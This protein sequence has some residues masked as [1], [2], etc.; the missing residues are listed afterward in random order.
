[1]FVN[2]KSPTWL[3]F[4]PWHSKSAS[5]LLFLLFIFGLFV[6]RTPSSRRSWCN[7][8]ECCIVGNGVRVGGASMPSPGLLQLWRWLLRPSVSVRETRK[9]R[10]RY[11]PATQNENV[12][13]QSRREQ[14]VRQNLFSFSPPMNSILVAVVS[15]RKSKVPWSQHEAYLGGKSPGCMGPKWESGLELGGIPAMSACIWNWGSP[16]MGPRGPP[17]VNQDL[18]ENQWGKTKLENANQTLKWNWKKNAVKWTQQKRERI[19]KGT[20]SALWFCV[21]CAW[22]GGLSCDCMTKI[23][24][25]QRKL[26]HLA[27][28]LRCKEADSQPQL[29][30]SRW[31]CAT[32]YVMRASSSL[33]NVGN[34]QL[35]CCGKG[36]IPKS[37]HLRIFQSKRFYT[38]IKYLTRKMIHHF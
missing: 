3:H 4:S 8:D 1:M 24:N 10:G 20:R 6:N 38:L 28:G 17:E 13:D 30:L 19:R 18:S 25:Q 11:R 16:G 23:S 7:F 29:S 27:V 12:S 15:P 2:L 34:G 21:L 31:V 36:P 33:R 26:V 35:N 22:M 5:L 32:G 9:P 14:G 37:V